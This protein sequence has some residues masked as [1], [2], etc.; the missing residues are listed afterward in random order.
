MSALKRS[1]EDDGQVEAQVMANCALF[2]LSRL[3][4]NNNTSSSS[5]SNYNEKYDFECKTCNKRFRLFRPSVATV[6]VIIN[7]QNYSE[8]FLFK[9]KRIRCINALF[10][11][12]SFS[13]VKP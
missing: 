13:W 3:N 11:V 5:S 12:W 9:P 10:V 6:Q 7:D 4:N 2:L 8:S 1:R